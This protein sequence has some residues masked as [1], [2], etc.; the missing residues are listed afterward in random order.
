TVE[1]SGRACVHGESDHAPVG[2]DARFP[3]PVQVL[4]PDGAGPVVQQV[5]ELILVGEKGGDIGVEADD[6]GYLALAGQGR[7]E[8]GVVVTANLFGLQGD[9]GKLPGHLRQEAVVDG[10]V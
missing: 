5:G 10:A 7:P 2:G 9:V 6:V 1:Q 8:L 3:L 4:V